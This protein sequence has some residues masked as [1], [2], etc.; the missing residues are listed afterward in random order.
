[1]IDPWNQSPIDLHVPETMI[2]SRRAAIA[3]RYAAKA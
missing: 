1:M 3:R 2:L